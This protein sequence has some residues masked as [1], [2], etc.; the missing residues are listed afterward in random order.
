VNRQNDMVKRL[1]EVIP[2]LVAATWEHPEH[3]AIAVAE[4]DGRAL[5][6]ILTQLKEDGHCPAKIETLVVRDG[7]TKVSDRHCSMLP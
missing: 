1:E 6:F 7:E 2:P 3:Q 4:Q 5:G